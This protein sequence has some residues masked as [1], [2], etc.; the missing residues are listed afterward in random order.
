MSE[1]EEM[2]QKHTLYKLLEKY[3]PT[4]NIIQHFPALLILIFP[5]LFMHY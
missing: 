3:V 1:C 5:L 2:K 4:C